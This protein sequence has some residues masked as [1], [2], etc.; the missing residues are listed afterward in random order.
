MKN[1][2]FGQEVHKKLGLKGIIKTYLVRGSL[3]RE[4]KMATSFEPI[5]K[6]LYKC[7]ILLLAT[8]VSDSLIGP[9]VLT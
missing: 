8:L 2:Y 1:I 9:L 7:H 6:N 5:G 4:R 3:L